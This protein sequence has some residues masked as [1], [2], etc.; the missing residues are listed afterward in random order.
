M[1]FFFCSGGMNSY[2]DLSD[3]N[4]IVVYDSHYIFMYPL[5]KQKITNVVV[6]SL[7]ADASYVEI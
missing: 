2:C 1:Y 6:G 5:L 3:V 4:Y 7:N